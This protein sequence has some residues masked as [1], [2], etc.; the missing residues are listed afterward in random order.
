MRDISLLTGRDFA[1][2]SDNLVVYCPAG[3]RRWSR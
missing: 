1:W 2:R 3:S